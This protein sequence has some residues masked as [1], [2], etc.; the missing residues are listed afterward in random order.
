MI[1]H[2]VD[3]HRRTGGACQSVVD[4]GCWDGQSTRI[5]AAYFTVAL[6]IDQSEENI[7]WSWTLSKK[8]G[9]LEGAMGRIKFAVAEEGSLI[10]AI[11]DFSR[12]GKVDM[13]IVS[14]MVSHIH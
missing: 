10:G 1:A 12:N 8:L 2:V 6:G 5:L 13:V 9:P 4:V 3:H 11:Q 14:G 7:K